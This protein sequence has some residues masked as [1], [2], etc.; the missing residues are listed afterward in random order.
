MKLDEYTR[1][2]SRTCADLGS[3]L[4]NGLHMALGMST[5]VSEIEDVYKKLL[6]YDKPIDEVNEKE[7]MGDLMWYVVNHCRQKGWDLEEIMATNIAK[8]RA[9]YPEKFTQEAALNRNLEAERKIL[10]Q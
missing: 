3:D 7:E 6:A 5:E 1:E 8:L 2:A 9:R 4:L 10:E